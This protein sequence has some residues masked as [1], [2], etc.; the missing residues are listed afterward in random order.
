MKTYRVLECRESITGIGVVWPVEEHE[1]LGPC[2]CGVVQLQ[3]TLLVAFF[4]D[5]K[6][7]ENYVAE[8]NDPM[9][10]QPPVTSH[11]SPEVSQ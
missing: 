4:T 10:H 11:Q 7:A 1:N 3:N 6:D 5:R 8:K 2:G 9:G